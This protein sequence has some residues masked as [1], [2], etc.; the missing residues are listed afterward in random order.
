MLS[1]HSRSLTVTLSAIDFILNGARLK[2]KLGP[3]CLMSQGEKDSSN[4]NVSSIYL[5]FWCFYHG[6]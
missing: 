4:I 3:S 5:C 2:C 6:L 1:N